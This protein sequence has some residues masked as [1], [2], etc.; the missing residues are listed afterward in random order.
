MANIFQASHG[1]HLES[2]IQPVNSFPPAARSLVAT[3]ILDESLITTEILDAASSSCG[4]VHPTTYT[5]TFIPS[6][7]STAPTTCTQSAVTGLA[8]QKTQ[9][10]VALRSLRCPPSAQ[11]V[12]LGKIAL[13]VCFLLSCNSLFCDL[14][15]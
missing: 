8:A 5:L 7:P 2:D 15:G 13:A 10:P 14:Q 6:R 11:T 1:C 3:E 4:A 9:S 12:L